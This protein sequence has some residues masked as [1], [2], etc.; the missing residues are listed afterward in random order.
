MQR[1]ED[2]A[3][4]LGA[5]RTRDELIPFLSDDMD[6]DDEVLR[7]FAAQLGRLLEAVGGAAHAMTLLMPLEQLASVEDSA[8]REKATESI[9][10]IARAVSAETLVAEVVPILQRLAGREWFTARISACTMCPLLFAALAASGG[11]VAAHCDTVQSTFLALVRDETPMVRRAAM[12]ALGPLARA[13]GPGSVATNKELLSAFGVLAEDQQDSVR[14]FA[15]DACVDFAAVLSSAGSKAHVLPLSL[16]LAEDTSWRV[17]WSVANK[18]VALCDAVGDEAANAAVSDAQPKSLL[19]AHEQLLQDTEMEVR[20]VAA[21]T[22]ADMAK[23]MTSARARAQL[24]PLVNKLVRDDCEHVRI[25]VASVIMALGATVTKM[26]DSSVFMA[27]MIPMYL[28]LLKVRC[29]LSLCVCVC[30]LC[31]HT[32]LTPSPLLHHHAC[33]PSPFA[34]LQDAKSD[35]RLNIIAKLGDGGK[36]VDRELSHSLQPAINDLAQDRQWRVRVAVIEL[37]PSLAER[38]GE[39]FFTEAL[40]ALCFG[41]IRDRVFAVRR[42]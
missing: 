10:G 33:S 5:D 3:S 25:A 2:I 14:L 13:M 26:G 34:A 36:G 32:V 29:S 17:R 40:R 15:I 19:D 20:A 24:L 12:I 35:V 4:A 6:D 31:M 22:V 16:K 39:D 8:V 41:C 21:V 1:L 7:E 38:L 42:E 11:A 27:E 18:F 23:K 30:V 28:E 9:A 37:M